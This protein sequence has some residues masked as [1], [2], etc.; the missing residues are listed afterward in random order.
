MIPKEADPS[1][2]DFRPLSLFESTR[3]V[4]FA[5]IL[6]KLRAAWATDELLHPAQTMFI[7]GRSMDMSVIS[8]L[9]VLET[10]REMKSDI[11]LSS[12]D[13]TKAFDRVPS[14]AQVWAY[15]RLGVPVEVAKYMVAFDVDCVAVVRTPLACQAWQSG[16]YEGLRNHGY[17]PGVGM[18]Q[19]N[20]DSTDKW[21]A[22]FK[23]LLFALGMVDEGHFY[24]QGGGASASQ[25][26]DTAAADLV[27]FAGTHEAL[28][29]IADIVSAFCL[30]F[31]LEVAV[32]K[33]LRCFHLKWCADDPMVPDHIVIHLAGRRPHP[34]PLQTDGLMKHL[35]VRW[36]MSLHNIMQEM[37]ATEQ[38]SL[39]VERLTTMP[40]TM[41][42]KKAVL[43]GSVF[44]SLVFHL[45]FAPWSLERFRALDRIVSKAFRKMLQLDA[46]Y[47]AA[48]LYMALSEGGMGCVRLSDLVHTRKL[49]LIARCDKIGSEARG[50]MSTCS[51]EGCMR[52]QVPLLWDM[53]AI[54]KSRWS[55]RR[56][57]L[58]G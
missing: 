36:D 56:H 18:A 9:N 55:R 31:G 35:G 7:K 10:A 52:Q 16:R 11:F 32:Q 47:P 50:L 23:P 19:G 13:I 5:L 45:K 37:L 48:L 58:R 28:Q 54:S 43:E 1:L 51:T 20:V 40:C 49:S 24:F 25:A 33:K 15:I 26:K 29:A 14:Q 21:A 44:Q 30:I 42:L 3:K 4:W 12:W 39:A 34:V 8:L 6:T 2:S 17:S 22:F 46:H 41:G 38:L 57:R 27:S 53:V